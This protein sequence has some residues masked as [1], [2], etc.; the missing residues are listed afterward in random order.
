MSSQTGQYI[1]FMAA[2]LVD[3]GVHGLYFSRRQHMYAS[4]GL[5]WL[6]LVAWRFDT[7]ANRSNG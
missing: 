2:Q 5:L 3:T 7:I 4:S 6:G 1:N